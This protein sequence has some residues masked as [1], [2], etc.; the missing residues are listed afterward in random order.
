MSVDVPAGVG[1]PPLDTQPPLPETTLIAS[2][3]WKM[4]SVLFT[5][6]GKPQV[7]L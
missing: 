2:E 7:S 4:L 5:E 6:C 3:N 1:A